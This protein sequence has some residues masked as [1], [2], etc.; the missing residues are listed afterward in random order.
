M[1][2]VSS[3]LDSKEGVILVSV[4]LGFGLATLFRKVCKEKGCY[5]IKGPKVSDVNQYYY[6]IEDKCYKYTPVVVQCE[7]DKE[8]VKVEA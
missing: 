5:V 6:K 4:I 8:I 2:K 7:K 3:M 1:R